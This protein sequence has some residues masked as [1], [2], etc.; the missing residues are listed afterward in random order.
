MGFFEVCRRIRFCASKH[1]L[2]KFLE[3]LTRVD[4]YEFASLD[5]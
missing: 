4:A 1:I 5:N 3:V 2:D